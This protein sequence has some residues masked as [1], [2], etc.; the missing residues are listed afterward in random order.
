[1]MN[2]VG[3]AVLAGDMRWLEGGVQWI[4]KNA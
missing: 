4:G 1:M 2:S 3:K